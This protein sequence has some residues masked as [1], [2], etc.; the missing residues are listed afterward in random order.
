MYMRVGFKQEDFF[1]KFMK[2]S[3]SPKQ[4]DA[5]VLKLEKKRTLPE[6][7]HWITFYMMKKKLSHHDLNYQM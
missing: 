7:V 6:T 3:R 2:M 5:V 1:F 4:L